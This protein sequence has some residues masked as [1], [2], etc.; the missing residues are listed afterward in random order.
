MKTGND[1]IEYMEIVSERLLD[2]NTLREQ[3][4]YRI[5]YVK[6]Q[7]QIMLVPL[8]EDYYMISF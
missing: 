4:I 2:Q 1:D 8:E 7:I 3:H 6:N 5:E